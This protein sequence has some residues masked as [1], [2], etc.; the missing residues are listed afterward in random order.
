MGRSRLKLNARA[1]SYD[2]VHAACFSCGANVGLKKPT[3]DCMHFNNFDVNT[4]L[5]C[6]DSEHATQNF[7]SHFPV[8]TL[9]SLTVLN[10]IEIMAQVFANIY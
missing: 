6:I 10:A 8:F 5:N 9:E 7:V 3:I 2:F 4:S 1:F